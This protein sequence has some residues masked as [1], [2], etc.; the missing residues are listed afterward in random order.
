MI[1]H[2]FY[3][4]SHKN[5]S[6]SL[7]NACLDASVF[8]SLLHR[9]SRPLFLH[10]PTV[11][12]TPLEHVSLSLVQLRPNDYQCRLRSLCYHHQRRDCM[13]RSQGM[14]DVARTCSWP[15]Q[16][17]SWYEPSYPSPIA[18]SFFILLT[19]SRHRARS[20]ILPTYAYERRGSR[21]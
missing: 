8:S 7:Q 11:P 13:A 19:L 15:R 3:Q 2:R 21:T 9:F 18:F 17:G 5:G 1:N 20:P 10:P 6:P 12:T 14:E 16:W 4:F